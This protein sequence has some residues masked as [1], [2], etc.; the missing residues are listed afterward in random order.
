MNS[1]GLPASFSSA[2]VSLTSGAGPFVSK[3]GEAPA[4]LPFLRCAHGYT[5]TPW[6]SCQYKA[7]Q[8]LGPQ[9]RGKLYSCLEFTVASGSQV[10]GSRHEGVALLWGILGNGDDLLLTFFSILSQDCPNLWWYSQVF[11]GRSL[12]AGEGTDEKNVLMLTGLF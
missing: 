5:H 4:L 3:Q 11:S 7:H 2:Y 1:G 9:E 10:A 8:K 12:M 6:L